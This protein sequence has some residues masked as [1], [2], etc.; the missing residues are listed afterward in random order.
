MLRFKVGELARVAH[1]H[2]SWNASGEIVEVEMVG[3][4]EAFST[5]GGEMLWD[6]ADYTVIWRGRSIACLDSN[7]LKL[8]DPDQ[9]VTRQAEEECTA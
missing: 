2:P 6:R 5:V 7:L 9:Q 4:F 3:P 1:A 8:G